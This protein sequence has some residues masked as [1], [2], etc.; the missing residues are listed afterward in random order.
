[1]LESDAKAKACPMT[2][3][4]AM[5]A[6]GGL[7]VQPCIG[8]KCMAWEVHHKSPARKTDKDGKPVHAWPHAFD[9]KDA[10]EPGEPVDPPEG[11][12]GMIPPELYCEGR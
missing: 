10:Y 6:E 5:D 8:S 4:S 7:K 2:M 9:G 3:V 12:C 11:H 1:M